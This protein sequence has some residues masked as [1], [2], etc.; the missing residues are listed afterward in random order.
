MRTRHSRELLSY[1]QLAAGFLSLSLA[2]ARPLHASMPIEESRRVLTEGLDH[3]YNLE[4]DEA[5]ASFERLR[6]DD[7]LSPIWQNHVALGYFYKELLQGGALEGD[8]FGASNKFFRTKK[9]PKD[10][11]L[12]N[13]FR[14]ANQEASRLCERR[15]KDDSRDTAALYSCGVAYAARATHQGLIERSALNFLGNARRAND[16]HSRLLRIN[17]RQYDGYL[18]PGLFDFVLGSLPGPV[19]V[20]F[21][22]A[23]LTGDKQRGLHLVEAAA[24]W[25]E[26]SKHDARIL[27]TVMYRREKRFDDARRTLESLA[28]AFPRNYIFPLEIASIHRAAEELPEAIRVY[29]QVLERFQAGTPN[30]AQAPAARIH[31]EL[32]VLYRRTGDLEAARLHFEQV[33]GSRGSTPELKKESALVLSQLGTDSPQ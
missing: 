5:I 22:F 26:R 30:F 20:L 31:F 2:L 28:A 32:G 18:I 17:P 6:T 15:L 8:L 12:G 23:G 25:G 3:F 21:F 29:E 10:S 9:F 24:D 7:P 33:A 27:L 16:Y 11:V 4:Y 13:R 1:G 19:K 14:Q